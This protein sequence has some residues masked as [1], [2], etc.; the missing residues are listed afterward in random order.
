MPNAFSIIAANVEFVNNELAHLIAA[1]TL[2]LHYAAAEQRLD[3]TGDIEIQSGTV[4]IPEKRE[5]TVKSKDVV[6]VDEPA[7]KSKYFIVLNPNINL[8]IAD[9]VHF[10]GFGLMQMLRVN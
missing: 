5:Q 4:T 8:R 2:N 1:S 9:G 3:I 7:V 10:Q 6:F